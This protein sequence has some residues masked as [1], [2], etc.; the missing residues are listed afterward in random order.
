[1]SS[2]ATGLT[3][4]SPVD[5]NAPTLTVLIGS[6]VAHAIDPDQAPVVIGRWVDPATASATSSDTPPADIPVVDYRISRQHLVLSLRNG[7]W[8]ATDPGSRNGTF[9]N[10]EKVDE[11]EIPEDDE[12][13]AHLGNPAAGIQITFSRSDAGVVY[14]GAQFAAA[15]RQLRLSQ[16]AL[17][18]DGVIN[19]GALIAFEKGRSWPRKSTREKLEQVVHW[20]KGTI[21]KLRWEYAHGGQTTAAASAPVLAAVP[22]PEKT[23]VVPP[24]PSPARE[25]TGASA[26][27]P[28]F[29][30]QWA[31]QN[32]AQARAHRAELPPA[33]KPAYQP[34]VA[35]L[36]GE[37]A[38]LE[39]LVHNAS[40]TPE[41][42]PMFMQVR[43][44]LREVMLAAAES[45]SAT[46]GQ[47]LFAIRD[48]DRLSVEDAA[49][50]AGVP[51]ESVRAFETGGAVPATDK[52]VL[53]NFLASLQ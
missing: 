40:A 2:P 39:L 23:V 52:A 49:K 33:S 17:A 45:P 15:R 13:I 34:A 9:I 47:R 51:A 7:R 16:R 4:S 19:A 5:D 37:L 28:G 41:L 20:K 10:G 1:M 35:R 53:E 36:I 43:N 38:S 14:A 6:S 31:S 26:I 44:E 25:E 50:L 21:E 18:S 27:A 48:R 42:R 8:F 3:S 29:L 22:D 46:S 32:L 30:A 11:F 24:S 12:I